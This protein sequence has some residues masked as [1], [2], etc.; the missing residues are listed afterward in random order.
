MIDVAS[1]FTHTSPSNSGDKWW[2]LDLGVSYQI[3][4][5]ELYNRLGD[6]GGEAA[7][8]CKFIQINFMYLHLC[9]FL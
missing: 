4:R 5:I 3:G 7:Q 6:P 2:R 9:V 1:D 8:Y